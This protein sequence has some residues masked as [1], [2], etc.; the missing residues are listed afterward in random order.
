MNSILPLLCLALAQDASDETIEGHP[1]RR[2]ATREATL[3]RM[4]AL[5]R[6]QLAE[7]GEWYLASPFP[8]AGHDRGD[9]ATFRAPE[10][11]LASMA[12]GGPGPDLEATFAGKD[13]TEVRW[14]SLGKVVDVPVDLRVHADDALNENATAFLWTTLEASSA[15]ELEIHC[16]SDDG[17]RLWLNGRLL[18][19]ADVP[20]G[21]DPYAHHLRL[22]LE[23][24]VNHLLVEVAQGLGGWDF[25]VLSREPLA[26][27][28]DALLRYLLD[29]DFPPSPERDHWRAF[30]VPVPDDVVLEV[31]GLAFFGD[32][33]PAVAT[34]RGDVFRVRDAYA[35][36]P[37]DATFER[38]A[39]GLHEPLGLAVRREGDGD[40]V[41]Y[42]AQR[43]EL[44]RLVDADGDGRADRYEAFYDGWGVSGN[45]H[46]FAFGPKFDSE[47]N[48]W[49]TLNVGFCGGLGKSIVPYRGWALKITPAGEAIPVC[50]GMR[51]PNGIAE[52]ADG[53][54]FYVDNQ[55]DYV[56]T[57]RLSVVAP[58]LWHGHPASL[59]WRT[60]LASPDER[61]PRQPAA[62]WFPYKKMGQSAADLALDTT[63]GAFGPFAGQFFV[64][65]QTLASVMRVALERV[66]G[67]WQG[68]CFP[69]LE[70]LDCGV[71]RLAFAPD[72][73]LF[74]G[75][76][77][78]GW[79]SVGDRR[80]GLQRIVYTGDEPF[81]VHSIHAR[82]DGFEL[83][84]TQAIDAD[85]A[86]DPAAY[87]LE[88]YTYEY[89]A[90]YGAPEA[91]TL[92]LTVT[93]A[94]VTSPTTVRLTVEPLRA[95][96]VHELRFR[97]L[98]SAAGKELLHDRAYYTLVNVP[99][100]TGARERPRV[101]FLTHSAGFVH[102]VVA[103]KD[104]YVLSTAEERL[105]EMAKGRFDV[106]ATQDPS[107]LEP[108]RLATFDAVVFYTTGELP[109]APAVLDNL[110]EWVAGGGAFTGIHSAADTLYEFGP[111]GD[112]LGGVFDGHPWTQEVRVRVEDAGHPATTE[113]GD[114]FT[115]D[116]E[117]YQFRAFRRHP[118]RVL[119]SVDPDSVDLSRGSRPDGDYALA[120]C[121]DYGSGRVFYTALGHR[122]EVWRD[123]RFKNLLLG[124]I[125]WTLEG[126]DHVAAPPSAATVLVDGLDLTSWRH[127]DGRDAGWRLVDGALE[128]VPGA[129]DLVTE[130]A[131]GDGLYH[132]EFLV[133]EPPEGARGQERGNSGVYLQGRYE[134]QVLD[135]F[136]EEPTIDGCGA[137]YGLR[138]PAVNACRGPE[139][140]QSYDI[141]FRA[142]RFDAEGEKIE[143]ARL[144]AWLNGRKIHDDVVIDG[145]TRGGAEAEA[146]LGPLLLQDHSAPVRYRNVWVLPR[147]E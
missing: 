115:I 54:L 52:Y 125:G 95:G 3:E 61:P 94:Q 146:P 2:L 37:V 134:L 130:A 68:A 70:H 141:E 83:V 117:I 73:S 13:G 41:V 48:A 35:E 122:P 49:V 138:P 123:P 85:S 21:L 133:P 60:D 82:E 66:D 87:E 22:P 76:T 113:L 14:R 5:L 27:R 29:R 57:N 45:Y 59:R 114:S 69:F 31:G 89:H 105:K 10:R 75:Q 86:A 145:P 67:H 103:R 99:G 116:D 8:Y 110:V 126:P 20:R 16:G 107:W 46:E 9:L 40:E 18:I 112:M 77:D 43:A 80:Y 120:W 42:A 12:A 140:W 36:P 135:S 63:N 118:V 55:G 11:E 39:A 78:R 25:Q 139:E 84:F 144:T 58:G 142:A 19:D 81:E 131:L 111:Y 6:P 97:G 98:A 96:Y 91:D 136:G 137:L 30:T 79:G 93:A 24:G 124:G 132:V 56:A 38:F 71:N 44:T 92:P 17:M 101:L 109:V 33:S 90:E 4:E 15:G 7:W 147:G 34:R 64:G 62:V 26:G 1:Y 51:S 23:Q 119:L 88:S 143:P 65:D 129:G 50:D 32:G 127:P 108:E 53:T 28:T 102:D 47:G 121:R 106:F 74:V 100:R 72:G 128:V 104:P